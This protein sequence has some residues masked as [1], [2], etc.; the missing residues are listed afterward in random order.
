MMKCYIN[1]LNYYKLITMKKYALLL[2][3]IALMGM[4]S[5]KRC[6][7]CT[8]AIGNPGPEF[9]AKNRNTIK[10]FKANCELKGGTVTES[11]GK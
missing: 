7:I 6:Y 11:E 8:S 2:T 5:C 1:G 3:I 9:C 4:T 10:N